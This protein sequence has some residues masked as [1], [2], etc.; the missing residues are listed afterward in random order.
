MVRASATISSVDTGQGAACAAASFMRS[1]PPAL[2]CAC[3]A[4]AASQH[5][6]ACVH[7]RNTAASC[8]SPAA[9]RAYVCC[10]NVS[11]AAHERQVGVCTNA[12]C[13]SAKVCMWCLRGSTAC[14]CACVCAAE[15]AQRC[16]L[17]LTCCRTC[18]TLAWRR[19][20]ATGWRV[21]RLLPCAAGLLPAGHA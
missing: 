9:A 3:G 13:C 4:C 11:T 7:S 16:L 2:R 19:T 8:C 5:A 14:V 15:R 12:E 1:A 18:T 6:C 17:L 10:H 20:F 21:Q